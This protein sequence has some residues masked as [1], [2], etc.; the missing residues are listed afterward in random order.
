M[1]L[2]REYRPKGIVHCFSGSAETAKEVVALGMYVGFTGVVTFKKDVYK[3]QLLI[4][5]ALLLGIYILRSA[6]NYVVQ[7]FGHMVGVRMQADMRR[8]LFSHLQSLPFSY[9]DKNKTGAIMSRIVNDLM[10]ISELAHHGPEDVFISIVTLAG[11]FVLMC[12]RNI[13]RTLIIFAFIPCLVFFAMRKRIKMNNAFARRREE[14]AGIN[15][16]VENSISG[17]R[18]AKAFQNLDNEDVYKRQPYFMNGTGKFFFCLFRPL[19]FGENGVFPVDLWFN[20]CL[21]YTSI[22]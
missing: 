20:S 18:V 22:P 4:W 15:A 5:C 16:T 14:V 9:F 7:Y 17:I 8:D 13:P 12:M 11:S 21:L 1:N 10:E 2:L 3:R 19:F 6:L